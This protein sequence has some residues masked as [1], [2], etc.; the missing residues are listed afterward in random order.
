MVK[1]GWNP[2]TGVLVKRK[3]GHRHTHRRHH[4][5]MT[6]AE[7]VHLRGKEAEGLPAKHERPG[8]EGGNR[9]LPKVLRRSNTADTLITDFQPPKP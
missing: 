1:G 3:S 2:R 6:E 7:A 4:M 5:R 9:L 8:R